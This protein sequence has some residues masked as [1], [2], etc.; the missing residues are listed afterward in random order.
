M[1]AIMKTMFGQKD[2]QS[3]G[4]LVAAVTYLKKARDAS[5]PSE[6]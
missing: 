3:I 6:R 1:D 2:S 5:G 4:D